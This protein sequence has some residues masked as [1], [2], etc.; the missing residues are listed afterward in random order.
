MIN[1]D[2]G[3]DED[4]M[5]YTIHTLD[6]VISKADGRQLTIP[7]LANR[8]SY[9]KLSTVKTH[10]HD[11]VPV[12]EI[13]GTSSLRLGSALVELDTT[14]KHSQAVV[15]KASEGR[16]LCIRWLERNIK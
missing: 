4:D 10:R 3:E 9:L 12:I 15:Q 1:A 14:A 8:I 2:L 16:Q 6:L 13:S 11:T 5:S 7:A